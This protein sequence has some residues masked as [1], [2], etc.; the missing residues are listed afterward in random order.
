VA[1]LTLRVILFIAVRFTMSSHFCFTMF[2]SSLL[3]LT[4]HGI[5]PFRSTPS[6]TWKQMSLSGLRTS[7]CPVH[8]HG[9]SEL[10]SF[11]AISKI[12]KKQ[13]FYW[14]I[15]LRWTQMSIS[16]V[17]PRNQQ[18]HDTNHQWEWLIWKQQ[19]QHLNE[20]QRQSTQNVKTKRQLTLYQCHWTYASYLWSLIVAQTFEASPDV[21]K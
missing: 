8:T 1:A 14:L 19:W 7:P 9:H 15:S 2:G 3:R 5:L 16:N 21:S 6:I 4:T 20:L 10:T 11:T 12:R 17:R 13:T 18:L